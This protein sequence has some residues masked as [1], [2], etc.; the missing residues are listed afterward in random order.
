MI[1]D[2]SQVN[3]TLPILKRRMSDDVSSLWKSHQK[4]IRK[5]TGSKVVK[6]ETTLRISM[7]K[8]RERIS[9]MKSIEEERNLEP[10][11]PLHT[12]PIF[13]FSNSKSGGESAAKQ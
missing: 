10:I 2:T 3:L 8:R 6:S 12:E 1:V 9:M 5:Q 11:E 4:L 7:M 13:P